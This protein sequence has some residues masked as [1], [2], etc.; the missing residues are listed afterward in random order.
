M[1]AVD[2]GTATWKTPESQGS[3]ENRKAF[4]TGSGGSGKA[5]LV[6][7]SVSV[8]SVH[9]GCLPSS[10]PNVCGLNTVSLQTLFL[11]RL[12]KPVTWMQLH[13]INP[14]PCL[15]VYNNPASLFSWMQGHLFPAQLYVTITLGFPVLRFLHLTAPATQPQPVYLGLSLSSLL[16]CGSP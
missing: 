9:R 13:P 6:E 14:G 1:C 16:F 8:T 2:V 15:F 10:S 11:P 4:C 7:S 5:S 3:L 12:A